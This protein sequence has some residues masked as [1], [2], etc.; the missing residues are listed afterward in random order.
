VSF[1][2]IT[3]R[4]A[5]ERAIPKESVYFFIDSVRK[6]LD[7]PSYFVKSSEHPMS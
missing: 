6:L 5:S 7:T 2:V 3:P 1:A 4:V